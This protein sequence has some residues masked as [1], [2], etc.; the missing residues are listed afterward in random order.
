MTQISSGIGLIS[1]LPSADIIESLLLAQSRPRELLQQRVTGINSQR[2]ALTELSA[3]LLALDSTINRLGEQS[4]FQRFAANSSNED[5]LTATAGPGAAPGVLNL[6]VRSLVTN[7]QLIS[8]G[9]SDADATPVGAGE[10]TIEVGN[11]RLNQATRL[12]DLNGGQGVRQGKF[13]IVDRAGNEAVIDASAAIDVQQVLDAINGDTTINV[14]ASISGNAIVIEDLNANATGSLIVRDQIGGFVAADLGIAKIASAAAPETIV[15]DDVIYLTDS[16]PLALLN[17]G[18]G[19]RTTPG[20]DDFTI[21]SAD[22]SVDFGVSLKGILSDSTRLE[23][24]NSGNGVRLGEIKITNRAGASAVIDLTAAETAGDVRNLISSAVD[25]SGASLDV[26]ASFVGANGVGSLIITDT[27]APPL[28]DDVDPDDPST[29][30][31]IIEDV[32]GF[33]ARDLGIARDTTED[34]FVGNGVYR[35]TT[36]G[37]VVRAINFADGNFDGFGSTVTARITQNGLE[38]VDPTLGAPNDTVVTA[39]GASLAARDLGI[40]GTFQDQLQTRHLLAGLNTV[41]LDSLNGGSGVQLGT[42]EFTSGAGLTTAIDLAG[43]Q[44]VQDVLDRINATTA[45][46]GISA[47]LNGVGHGIAIT[48]VSGGAGLLEVQDLTGSAAADL[49]FSGTATGVLSGANAQLRYVAENTLL[50]DLN[51]GRGV[52]N[53]EIEIRTTAGAIFSVNIGASQRTVGNV[54]DLINAN[55]QSLGVTASINANGD[56][57]LITDSNDGNQELRIRDVNGGLAATDLN[58][59]Q[60]VDV[61]VGTIDGSY[62]IRID[63]DADDT[64]ADV[65]QKISDSSR[66]VSASVINDGAS[67]SSFRLSINSEVT[68]KRGEL[69]FDGTSLGLN[70]RTLVK[71]QD[72]VALIGGNSSSPIVISSSTNT[73]SGVIPGVDVDLVNTSDE[74]VTLSITPDVEAVVEDLGRFVADYNAVIDRIDELTSFDPETEERGLLLGDSTV[75]TIE[76]RLARAV[77]GRFAGASP[78]ASTLASVGITFGNGGRL[79]FDEDRFREKF[80][81]DPEAVAQLFTTDETGVGAVLAETLDSLTNDT[82]GA[83]TR[84]DGVLVDQAEDLEDRIAALDLFLDR[85]REQLERQFANLESVLAGLQDQQNALNQLAALAGA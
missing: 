58:L 84:R 23:V 67:S 47:G 5:I 50:T 60:Q 49:G 14:R 85:R 12:G 13:E 27:S 39:V 15:G 18:N 68:G 3:R 56:G 64:L 1:G 7:H 16:T 38:L 37:D 42:V 4:A 77:I 66:E 72:A 24:L 32:T 83:L 53:G 81:E 79:D 35:I 51:G 52:R 48:D 8:G 62:E 78:N 30:H 75:S 46:S 40:E 76:N 33:A 54:I 19:I 22:G 6:S 82:D 11:G 36:I 31:L 21:T 69:I 73:L 65:A 9:F 28:A 74:T 63:V 80:A 43:A 61:G 45:T 41:L 29:P 26:S 57:I 44:T 70:M 10:I 17:D 25:A 55:G 2:T 59:A 20:G 71:A 34:S